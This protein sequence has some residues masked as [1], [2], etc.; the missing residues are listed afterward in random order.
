LALD[1]GLSQRHDRV[2]NVL[3]GETSGDL[4]DRLGVRC[5]DPENCG[6]KVAGTIVDPSRNLFCIRPL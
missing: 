4:D 2:I 3:A 6:K 1:G 5:R